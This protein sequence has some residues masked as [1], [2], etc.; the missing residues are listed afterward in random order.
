MTHS[1]RDRPR[2]RRIAAIDARRYDRSRREF[3]QTVIL[4]G[5]AGL[6]GR[7][8]RAATDPTPGPSVPV[9]GNVPLRSA[10]EMRDGVPQMV[11]NGRV[12]APFLLFHGHVPGTAAATPNPH[13]HLVGPDVK[14][15]EL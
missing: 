2:A 3:L 7:T 8:N 6:L 9:P 10:I 14:Q 15:I 12:E 5:S 11:V 4:A 13:Q 1:A